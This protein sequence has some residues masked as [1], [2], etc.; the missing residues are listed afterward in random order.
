MC[1]ISLKSIQLLPLCARVKKTGFRVF[2]LF[3]YPSIYPSFATPTGPIFSVI[4]TLNGSYDVFLQPLV[5]FVGSD[6]I[7]PDLGGQIP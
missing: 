4:L 5:P 6:E 7:A 2:F 1:K 3:T